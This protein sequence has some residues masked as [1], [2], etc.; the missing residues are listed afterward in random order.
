MLEIQFLIF[1][2]TGILSGFLAGLLG[3]GGGIVIVPAL[4]FTM[5]ALGFNPSDIMYFAT[6]TALASMLLTTLASFVLHL[7]KEGVVW[8]LFK[9]MTLGLVFGVFLA[10][11]FGHVYSGIFLQL[12]FASFLILNGSQFIFS[13]L[14]QKKRLQGSYHL[15]SFFEA[16]CVS[17]GIGFLSVILGVAGGLFVGQYFSY[18]KLEIRKAISTASA[19]S[20]LITFSA[21]LFY[22]A[23]AGE[24]SSH[25]SHGKLFFGPIYLPAFSILSITSMIA[26]FFGVKLVYTI[27]VTKTKKIF[28]GFCIL[29]GLTMLLKTILDR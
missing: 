10:V 26:A 6:S 8:M 2:L 27:D 24:F 17:L 5:Q 15:P 13:F 3:I 21:S 20:F 16:S 23:L 25:N 29:I 9:K 7:R 22:A 14:P 1:V 4:F 28:G 18:K 19:A 11:Y 12:L